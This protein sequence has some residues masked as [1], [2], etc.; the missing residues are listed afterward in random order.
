V[1][2]ARLLGGERPLYLRAEID[3]RGRPM[4]ASLA[5]GRATEPPGDAKV[6]ARYLTPYLEA[7]EPPLKPF[8]AP[9]A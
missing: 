7:H 5:A 2:R 9:A 1:L 4:A 3:A 6:F 8:L